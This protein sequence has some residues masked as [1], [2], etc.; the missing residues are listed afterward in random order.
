MESIKYYYYFTLLSY[1]FVI[2]SAR[3]L[4]SRYRIQNPVNFVLVSCQNQIVHGPPLSC[5]QKGGHVPLAPVFVLCR[6]RQTITP[7]RLI[8]HATARKLIQLWKITSELGAVVWPP[9]TWL[10]LSSA[11]LERGNNTMYFCWLLQITNARN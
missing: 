1:Q 10:R 7:V 5:I 8:N 9:L 2:L 11:Y 4:I 3:V 6:A